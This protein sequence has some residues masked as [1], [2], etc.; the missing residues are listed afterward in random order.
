VIIPVLRGINCF[1]VE[2]LESYRPASSSFS[3]IIEVDV[4]TSNHDGTDIFQFRVCTAE[5]LQEKYYDEIVFLRGVILV[6]NFSYPVLRQRIEKLVKSISAD[7]WKEYATKLSRWGQ[8][9][10]EDDKDF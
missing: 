9:E 2:N 1:D 7:D 6:T 3:L 10:F 4:G 5:W 8:W